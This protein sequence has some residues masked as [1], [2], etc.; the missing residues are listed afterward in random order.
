MPVRPK[1]TATSSA[2]RSTSY[3]RRQLAH[4]AQIARR[5]HDHAGGAL[6]QRLDDH[7]G[8]SL[9][10]LG[11]TA[12]NWSSSRRQ[13]S[14]G[15]NAGGKA[16]GVGHRQPQRFEQQRLE[17]RVKAR[18]AADAHAAERVAVVGFAQRDVK[19]SFPAAGSGRCRQY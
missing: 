14:I 1:P 9:V 2:I 7:R 15:R 8:D 10:V 17:H 13:A 12:S 6:H 16:V 18:H 19:S 11:S 3:L 5:M 4:A